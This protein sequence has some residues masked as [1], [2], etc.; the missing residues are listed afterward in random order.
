MNDPSDE[1]GSL[2]VT[3]LS[4]DPLPTAFLESLV[5]NIFPPFAVII[6][7]CIAARHIDEF[8]EYI[9]FP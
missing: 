3:P 2:E 7:L 5:K 4:V 6:P 8:A 9:L 1:V